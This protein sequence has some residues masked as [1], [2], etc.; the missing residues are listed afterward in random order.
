MENVVAISAYNHI[1]CLKA[2]GI[3][4]GKGNNKYG[5]LGYPPQ[6]DDINEWKQI[7]NLSNVVAVYALY[8]RSF[9]V[10]ADGTVWGCGLNK[11]RILGLGGDI[12]QTYTPTLIPNISN[13]IS[14]VGSDAHTL[15]LRTNGL[16][17]GSGYNKGNPFGLDIER[18]SGMY[19]MI[20]INISDVVSIGVKIGESYFVKSDGTVWKSGGYRSN[21]ASIGKSFLR[22][23]EGLSSVVSVHTPG[24]YIYY[25]LSNGDLIDASMRQLNT[26]ATNVLKVFIHENIVYTLHTD[27][28]VQKIDTSNTYPIHKDI[29]DVSGRSKYSILLSRNGNT[30]E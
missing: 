26:V 29:I 9:F 7:P 1:L 16:V 2:D 17:Y 30:I 24:P 28:T 3:V 25:I 20:R 14:I 6:Q 21:I 18:E 19:D 15:F 23:I 8:Y 12:L 13:V 10:K 5:Q 11:S 22:Q 4:Y 27:G